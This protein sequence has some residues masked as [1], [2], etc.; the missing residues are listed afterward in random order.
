MT[1]SGSKW[2][3]TGMLASVCLVMLVRAAAAQSAPFEGLAIELQ[4]DQR[5]YV[6]GE[7]VQLTVRITNRSPHAV[8]IPAAVDVWVGHVEVFIAPPD[9]DYVQYLG[10]G[11]G[12]RDLIASRPRI[13][14]RGQS[15]TTEAAILY[16]HGLR[17][18]HLS[19]AARTDLQGRL[20]H[21]GFAFQSPGVYRIKVL[22]HGSGFADV[23]ES[24]AAEIEVTEP[25]GFDDRSVWHA[26]KSAPDAAYFLHTG[27]LRRHPRG[28]SSPP[29]TDMLQELATAYPWSRYADGIQRRLAGYERALE[30]VRDGDTGNR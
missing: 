19:R 15:V 24:D 8:A 7:A 14:E 5:S 25:E 18:D 1:T 11:W 9:G 20:R 12:L 16:N 3:R 29:V 4:P 30:R 13:L 17:T 6:L 23:A 2:R 21:S 27:G 26:L 28:T 10:P 22:M